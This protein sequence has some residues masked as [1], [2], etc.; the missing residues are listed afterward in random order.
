MADV[1]SALL[2]AFLV[3]FVSFIAITLYMDNKYKGDTSMSGCFNSFFASF[4]IPL[5]IFIAVFLY[6]FSFY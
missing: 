5:I 1:F 3:S 2:I 4:F 6:N